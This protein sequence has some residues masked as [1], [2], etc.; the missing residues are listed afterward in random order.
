MPLTVLVFQHPQGRGE[1]L[2]AIGGRE[3]AAAELDGGQRRGL[4]DRERRVR[5]DQ[6]RA[7]GVGA[8]HRGDRLL[9]DRL[10]GAGQLLVDHR[11]RGR[12]AG[13]G[14]GGGGGGGG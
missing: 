2:G 14:E 1:H 7:V 11:Q 9:G 12:G 5:A 6:R 8:G 4:D 13:G 10:R 3:R